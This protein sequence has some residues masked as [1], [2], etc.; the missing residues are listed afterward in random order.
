MNKLLKMF[1]ENHILTNFI[2]V[3]VFAFAFYFWGE[4]PKEEMPETTGDHVFITASYTGGTPEEIEYFLTKNIEEAVRGIEGIDKID[5]TSSNGNVSVR[6]TLEMNYPYYDEAVTNIREAVDRVSLPEDVEDDP[7]IREVRSTNKSVVQIALFHKKEKLLSTEGRQMVQD[8]GEMLEKRLRGIPYVNDVSFSGNEDESVC[9]YIRPESLALYEISYSDAVNTLSGDNI[10]RP[11]GTIKNEDNARVTIRA[12]LDTEQKIRDSILQGSFSGKMIR[13]GDVA[14]VETT[15]EHSTSI[16]KFNG[17]QAL[18]LNVRKTSESGIT[19]ASD[20]IR[21]EVENFFATSMR[22]S[23]VDYLIYS[24]SAASVRDRLKLI[25]DNGIF[26]FALIL[27]ILFIFLNLTAGF[28]VAMGIPFALLFTVVVTRFLG[29]SVNNMT[30]SGIVIVLGMVVDDA[31][32]IAENITRYKEEGY[33]QTDAAVK[34]TETV[35][36]PVLASVLTTCVAFVPL[37]FFTGAFGKMIAVIPAMIFAM[38]GG[39]LLEAIFILPSHM[40]LHLPFSFGKRK[41]IKAPHEAAHWFRKVEDGY[42]RLLEKVLKYRVLLYIVFS[43]L[44]AGAGILFAS[45]MSFALSPREETNEIF[46]TGFVDKP[47]LTSAETAGYVEPLEELIDPYLGTTVAIYSTRIA[48]S[49]RGSDTNE[50][51]FSIRLELV[52]SLNRQLSNDE[53][54]E[55]LNADIKRKG[56]SY[57]QFFISKSRF[58]S[59]ADAGG[60]PIVIEI[61]ENDDD[62]R[63]QIASELCAVMNDYPFYQNAEI[64]NPVKSKQYLIDYDR[65]LLQRLNI[66]SSEISNSL[67]TIIQGSTVFYHYRDEV[68]IPVKVTLKDEYATDLQTILKNPVST[69]QGYLV[70]IGTVVKVKESLEPNYITRV[71]EHRVVYLYADL[72]SDKVTPVDTA[73]YFENE[74]FP[75]LMAKYPTSNI[76]FRGEV[77]Q[78][79]NSSGDIFFGTTLVL[80]LI[81]FILSLLFNSLW[82]PFVIVII[83]PFGM[84][85]VVYALLLHNMPVISFFTAV[86]MLGLA[87]VVVNDSIVM[88]DKLLNSY[89]SESGSSSDRRKAIADISK[90]RLRAVVL[91]TLTTVAGLLPTAYGI[92]G[93][94]SMLSDMMLA[95][96]YGLLTSTLVTLF[97]TP[98]LFCSIQAVKEKRNKKSREISHEN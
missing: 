37:Y 24:D 7:V 28:W 26:G 14:D 54:I 10:R 52:P 89:R 92:L 50:N 16:L 35:I 30:L 79:R 38:L 83:I 63:E 27:L 88:F 19:E 36:L 47:K 12:E 97:L 45:K 58:G 95:M 15:F 80:L 81:Y 65:D 6:I 25:R 73:E 4:I 60:S 98:A 18:N 70:P 71:N 3:L 34:G 44:L 46:I 57:S 23:D 11:L 13:I 22:D 76:L 31:I 41:K 56:L 5:S 74:V 51:F 42:G 84:M 77:E 86:G 53:L 87:G 78:T 39:S 43:V 82:K 67:R 29:Y 40:N 48:S 75:D 17:H 64:E 61:Q 59:T 96:S 8:A 49:R 94:D 55:A 72:S 85:G 66:S 90:T 1:A 62:K 32:V 69:R 2:V 20:A 91:T 33:G 21:A 93:Y 68:E 9:V